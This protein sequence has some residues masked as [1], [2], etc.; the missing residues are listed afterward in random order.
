MFERNYYAMHPDMILDRIPAGRWGEPS[1][2][3]GAAAFLASAAS[4]C[5]NG[6]IL[7]VHGDWLAR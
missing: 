4:N 5:V 2:L 3:G 7:A 6:H 1:H